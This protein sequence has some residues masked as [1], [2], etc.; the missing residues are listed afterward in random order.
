MLSSS[1]SIS[2]SSDDISSSY[3]GPS[4]SNEQILC[5]ESSCSSSKSTPYQPDPANEPSASYELSCNY[6]AWH[7]ESSPSNQ[8]SP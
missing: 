2:S 1:L 3:G 7:D 8:S 5:A 6:E 4:Q